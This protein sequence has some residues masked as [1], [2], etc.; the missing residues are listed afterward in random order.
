MSWPFSIFEQFELR[1]NSLWVFEKGEQNEFTEKRPI[2]SASLCVRV[3]VC[4]KFC[5][6]RSSHFTLVIILS[7]R[8]QSGVR[9]SIPKTQNHPRDSD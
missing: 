4:D 3:F 7:V 9:T 6:L 8:R 1:F 5:M 2:F